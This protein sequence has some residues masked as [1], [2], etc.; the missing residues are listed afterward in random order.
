MTNFDK[1]KPVG[2]PYLFLPV[3]EEEIDQITAMQDYIKKHHDDLPH[4]TVKSMMHY[5]GMQLRNIMDI[6][7]KDTIQQIHG[8][9]PTI[10]VT[11]EYEQG[12]LNIQYAQFIAFMLANKERLPYGYDILHAATQILL[13]LYP[14]SGEEA[15]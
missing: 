14:P 3:T 1:Q 11:E 6:W 10:T 7:Q 4:M 9:D 15:K 8:N 12:V 2:I 13:Q 5:T